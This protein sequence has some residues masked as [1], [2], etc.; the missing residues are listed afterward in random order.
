MLKN[1][2]SHLILVSIL[3]GFGLNAQPIQTPVFEIQTD[4]IKEQILDFSF[5]EVLEASVQAVAAKVVAK[6]YTMGDYFPNVNKL[7]YEGPTVGPA[8]TIRDA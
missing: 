6:D 7:E 8:K 2:I 4:T 3:L 5:V 1:A